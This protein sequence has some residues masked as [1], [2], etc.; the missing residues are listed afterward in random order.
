MKV[1]IVK[2]EKVLSTNRNIRLIKNYSEKIIF[3]STRLPYADK[4]IREIWMNMINTNN[5]TTEDIV[6]KLQGL[7]GKSKFKFYKSLSN[8]FDEMN[9]KNRV[10]LFNLKKI[11]LV[12]MLKVLVQFIMKYCC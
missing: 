2:I 3:F 5:N 9:N 7:K 11:L 6:D 1:T 12:K 4:R 10:V 8:Y